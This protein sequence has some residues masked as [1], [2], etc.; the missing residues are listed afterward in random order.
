PRFVTSPRFLWI[1]AT[2]LLGMGGEAWWIASAHAITPVRGAALLVGAMVL[3]VALAQHARLRRGHAIGSG[4]RVALATIA[5]AVFW[6][7]VLDSVLGRGKVGPMGLGL[8]ASLLA[9]HAAWLARAASAQR[10]C[11]QIA[12]FCACLALGQHVIEASFPVHEYVPVPDDPKAG[13]YVM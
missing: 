5:G 1:A 3:L 4:A 6:L 11:A 12:I 13:D 8:G 10:R 9:A 7:A 2:A